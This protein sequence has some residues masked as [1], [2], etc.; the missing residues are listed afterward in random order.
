VV[1]PTARPIGD[2][3]VLTHYGIGNEFRTTPRWRIEESMSLLV[4]QLTG[5][6]AAARILKGGPRGDGSDCARYTT[7]GRLRQAGFTVV[8]TPNRKNP[9]HVSVSC[10]GP[11]DDEAFD[12]CFQDAGDL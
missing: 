6:E 12:G 2:K 11:W 4:G 3:E 9:D 8:H 1:A 10:E 7:A 5:E